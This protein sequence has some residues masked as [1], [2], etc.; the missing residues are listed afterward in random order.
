MI[1]SEFSRNRKSSRIPINKGVNL[2]LNGVEKPKKLVDFKLDQEF[3]FFKRK[4]T[5]NFSFDIKK[6]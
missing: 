3:N 1:S 6:T 4:V 5:I 2:I